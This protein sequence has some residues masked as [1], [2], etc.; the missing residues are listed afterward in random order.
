MSD[1]LAKKDSVVQFERRDAFL[2]VNTTMQVDLGGGR[3]VSFQTSFSQAETLA[4]QRTLLTRLADLGDGLRMRYDLVTMKKTLVQQET[5]TAALEEDIGRLDARHKDVYDSK[6]KEIA[7][8]IVRIQAEGEERHKKSGRATAYRPEGASATRLAQLN[9]DLTILKHQGAPRLSD[10]EK[11]DRDNALVTLS[12]HKEK[13][14]ELRNDIAE[15]E[16]KLNGSG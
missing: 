15:A 3:V 4:E 2:P 7:E 16:A 14:Q 12:R 8:A 11:A 10:K 6:L 5:T 1:A 9:A 13:V